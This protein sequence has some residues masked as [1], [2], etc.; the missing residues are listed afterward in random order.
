MAS[1]TGNGPGI[2]LAADIGGTFTDIAAFDPLD[3]RLVF[4]KT[5]S[6]PDNLIEGI[7]QGVD[8]AELHFPK[9]TFFFMTV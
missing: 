2:R 1:E 4:G 7:A 6:T 8:K 9:Q 5:L 3:G